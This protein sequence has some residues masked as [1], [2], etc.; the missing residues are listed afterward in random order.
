MTLENLFN[1]TIEELIQRIQ[2]SEGLTNFAQKRAKFEG[3]FKV[4]L[5]DILN[6]AGFSAFPEIN[7]IDVSFQNIGIELKT[8][9]TN[10]N[11]QNVM[12]LSKPIT[13]NVDG[14]IKDV[15]KILNTTF[16]HKF[17]M[18]IVFPITHDNPN[19]QNHL[20]RISNNLE[21]YKHREFKFGLDIPGVIYL[22]KV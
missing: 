6:K 17:V 14:V 7:R 4:E 16:D 19:W 13:D 1:L 5:I 8:L 9:N 20:N 15:E 11:Y 10:V 3:W 2:N 18:F 22:G 12:K 21:D